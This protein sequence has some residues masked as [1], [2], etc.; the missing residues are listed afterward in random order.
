MTKS[1]KV[2]LLLLRLSMGWLLLYAG[3]SKVI[4]E[5]AFSAERYLT[6]AKSFVGLFQFFAQPSILP[7]VNFLNSW[8]QVLLGIALILGIGVRW[9]S[10]LA[11]IMMTLYYLPLSFPRPDDH[12]YIVNYH[13]IYTIGFLVLWATRAG[14]AYG[15]GG[16][17]A[18][19]APSLKKILA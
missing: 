8:G 11:A 19:Q 16:W 18:K 2:T 10:V 12:S 3:Y 13:F 6:G 1:E 17:L 7:F 14:S 15:L 9:T 5:P 4:A